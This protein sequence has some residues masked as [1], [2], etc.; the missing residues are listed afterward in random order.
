M[1]AQKPYELF[2]LEHLS[3]RRKLETKIVSC[4]LLY[5][6]KTLRIHECRH[7]QQ[8]TCLVPLQAK[9]PKIKTKPPKAESGTEC[10]GIGTALPFLSN[11]PVRGPMR[12]QPTRAQTAEMRENF[13]FGS[14][15]SNQELCCSP[16]RILLRV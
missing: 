7:H 5:A 1:L 8:L 6:N 14:T 4:K 3:P 15:A 11:L 13:T 16:F 2:A 10:P 12:T 9:N